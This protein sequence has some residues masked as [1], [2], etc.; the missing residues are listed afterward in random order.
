MDRMDYI[1]RAWTTY[2]TDKELSSYL[3]SEAVQ[4]KHKEQQET[5]ITDCRRAITIIEHTLNIHHH[6]ERRKYTDWINNSSTS[7]EARAFYKEQLGMLHD[8]KLPLSRFT[9]ISINQFHTANIGLK[10]VRFLL[11]GLLMASE[12]LANKLSYELDKVNVELMKSKQVEKLNKSESHPENAKIINQCPR[13]FKDAHAF[14]LFER[15]RDSF[16]VKSNSVADYSYIFHQMKTDELIF[17]AVTN[18]EYI[19]FLMEK[20]DAN[21]SQLKTL[22]NIGNI[23][24]KN[25][26]YQIAKKQ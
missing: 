21:I 5:Y 25:Y 13:I 4:F 19:R 16:D 11:K 24:G 15:L 17:D 2:E 14:M 10:D 23:K 7:D 9:T 12:N 1:L 22:N 6:K 3:V 26:T 20:Y 18:D 8:F